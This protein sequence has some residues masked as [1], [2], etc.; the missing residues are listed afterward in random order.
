MSVR[1]GEIRAVCRS[2]RTFPARRLLA[3]LEDMRS[4]FGDREAAIGRELTK[5]YE[6]ILRGRL[7]ELIDSLQGREVRGEVTLLVA[8]QKETG[9][10]EEVSLAEEISALQA[11]GLSLK[12]I[13]RLIGKKRG[14]AKRAV[15]AQ[16]LR[17]GEKSSKCFL[18]APGVC[19]SSGEHSKR[20]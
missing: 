17:L 20:G 9:E 18:S 4:I 11:Q 6:E 1:G 14:M 13:A 16:V 7:S 19:D 8:G 10:A 2:D 5:I 12:E 15:Y 3:C